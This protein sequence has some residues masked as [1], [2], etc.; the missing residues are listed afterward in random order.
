MIRNADIPFFH[1]DKRLGF[2]NGGLPQ[3]FFWMYK[4]ADISGASS[5]SGRR[6]FITTLANNGNSVRILAAA[7]GHR[8]I[9]VTQKYIDVN[10]DMIRNAV[11]LV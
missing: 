5:H 7:A 4:D 8:S 6:N 3:W 11:E 2:S 10:T 1:T 9:A